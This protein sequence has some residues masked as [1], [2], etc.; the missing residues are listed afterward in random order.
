[1][2]FLCNI[3][4]S[5]I[6]GLLYIRRTFRFVHSKT[7]AAVCVASSKKME[8]GKM[9]ALFCIVCSNDDHLEQY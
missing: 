8:N 4:V 7:Y 6:L 1:M 9:V 3:P 5:R 2:V